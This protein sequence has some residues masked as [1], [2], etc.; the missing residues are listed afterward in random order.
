MEKSRRSL[1]VLFI[2]EFGFCLV[3]APHNRE[4]D[5]CLHV[6]LP[7]PHSL[8]MSTKPV[9]TR[10]TT[11]TRAGCVRHGVGHKTPFSGRGNKNAA[12]DPRPNILQLNTEGLTAGKISVV[13]QQAYKNKAFIIVLQE[14]HW[15]QAS[16]SQ[17]LTSCV[18]PEQEPRPCHVCPW[19]VGMVT[20]LS[21][22]TTIRDGVVVHRHSRIQ[23]LTSTNLH[24]R[25]SHQRPSR[26]SH[27]PVC[28]LVTSTA[29]MSTGGAWDPGQYPATLDYCII[30]RKQPVA[31][32]TDGFASFGQDSR[33]P[34]RRVLGKF[35]WSQHRPSLI[36]PQKL[37]VPAS[38][39][40]VPFK[41][42]DRF[43]YARVDPIIDPLL[44]RDQAGFRHGRSALDQ[45]T[46]LTQHIENS[47]SAKKKAGT[48]F[49]D[50]TAA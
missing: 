39:L 37:K 33:L 22:T 24:A 46:L 28:M 49:V 38:L 20:D 47:F 25:H 7:A 31:S 30:Q 23:D 3:Y 4:D 41:I 50:L 34:D 5:R 8:Q 11:A 21:V 29:N 32:L 36:T 45:V 42:L 44:N 12:D 48:V 26:R 17:L 19:A 9:T 13:E 16:D 35:T 40:C 18:G 27:T 10:A 14:T 15:R 1:S 2:F 43:I 6:S